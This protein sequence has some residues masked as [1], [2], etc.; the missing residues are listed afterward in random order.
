[1]ITKNQW[2]NFDFLMVLLVCALVVIGIVAISSA[3]HV[4]LGE[5]PSV[6]RSQ[7]LFFVIG[8]ILL[9]IAS[10][11][12][13]TVL[14]ELYW[15]AYFANI[16]ILV[17]VLA[18]GKEIKGATR[19]LDIGFTSIQPSEFA[20]IIMIFCLAKYI[21]KRK[22][23]INNIF[24]L[25]S[26]ALFMFIP[27]FLIQKQPSLSASLVFIAIL[28]VELFVAKIDYRYIISTVG[29]ATSS[30]TGILWYADQ[31]NHQF[32]EK[33]LQP[34]QIRRIKALLHPELYTNTDYY[35]TNQSIS[36]IGSGQL[37]G[38]G[39][40]QGTLNQL[41]YLP[42]PHNDFIFSVI[43][44]E[45][46]FA[47]CMVILVIMFLIIVRC[48]WIAKDAK[49]LFGR[50]IATGVA[51]MLGFQTFVNVG[52]V[53]GILPNTGMT[54]PFLSSGGSSLWTNMIAIGLVL[55]VGM[56]KPHTLFK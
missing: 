26:I 46:G 56:R 44:E 49:D 40:Y 27:M 15:F 24:V 4:N 10:F 30:I 19:W 11:M 48:L 20:K 43:G 9:F 47:G 52:V 6:F 28:I 25:G 1:M 55:N 3:T 32:L 16:G 41:S 14:G 12:D 21:D 31:P 50:L 23:R 35:Q 18:F 37:Y 36:A 2:R 34:Y 53:T 29:I 5:D 39:L 13:Y 33:L 51:G 22:E 17:A 45:F 54:F 7:I 8:I 42:E 38:K